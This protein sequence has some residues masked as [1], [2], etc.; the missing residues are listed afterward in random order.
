MTKTDKLKL[1]KVVND[2]RQITQAEKIRF[3]RGIK[4]EKNE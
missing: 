2:S 1:I 4:Q 3:I